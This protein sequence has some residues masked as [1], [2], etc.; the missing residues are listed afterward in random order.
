MIRL[1]Q[2]VSCLMRLVG[3][4]WSF[5]RTVLN[6]WN[7][8]AE[9]PG[10][11]R[12]IMAGNSTRDPTPWSFTSMQHSPS[13][14]PTTSSLFLTATAM[15]ESSGSGPTPSAIVQV[16]IMAIILAIA[17]LGN[18]CLILIIVTDVRL[19]T[20]HNKMVINLAA[21]GLFTVIANG[22][23]ILST[24]VKEDWIYGDNW[25]QFN[26]F[27]TSVYGLAVVL[28]LALISIN[29][30]QIIG[31]VTPRRTP[32]ITDKRI[33]FAMA[34]E[35]AKTSSGYVYSLFL[36]KSLYSLY[37]HSF[38]IVRQWSLLLEWISSEPDENSLAE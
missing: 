26:G 20:V 24:L 6:Q 38:G 31:P 34:G 30:Y 12:G 1:D 29:R 33:P 19:R 15:E 3:R 7:L 16:T 25:C 18:V 35:K 28:T 32:W 21:C 11:A 8:V 36:K 5:L 2:N 4:I 27:T 37:F 17:L 13:S 23:F 10:Y 22:P 9:V 14:L